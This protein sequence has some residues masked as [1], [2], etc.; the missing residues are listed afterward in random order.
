MSDGITDIENGYYNN[1]ETQEWMNA[2]LGK[3]EKK[4]QGQHETLVS[5][6]GRTLEKFRLGQEVIV[7]DRYRFAIPL[8]A[9]IIQFAETNDGVRLRL[10][11]SNNNHYPI[12]CEDVW[13]HQ[14]QLRNVSPKS[15]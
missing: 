14:S 3:P 13:V 7:Y 10:I 15:K 2:P 6:Q 9:V 4:K 12:G 1:K 11:E 5:L 8:K